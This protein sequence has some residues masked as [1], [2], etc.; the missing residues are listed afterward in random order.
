MTQPQSK[1]AQEQR[2]HDLEV[3][4]RSREREI[5]LLKDTVTA[6]GGELDLTKVFEL[7][8]ERA[9]ELIQ[10]ETLLIPVLDDNAEHYT[11]RAG[12]GNNAAEIIGQS[13][14]LDFGVCGWVWRHKRAW[15]RGVLDELEPIERNRWENEAGTLIL[16]PMIGRGQFLGGLAG[17]NKLGGG[18]FTRQDLNLLSLFAGH[19]SIAIENAIAYAALNEAKLH[20]ETYQIE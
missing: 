11:Y 16:V 5:E 1:N 7:V 12:A 6:V 13:L 9:R 15:W 10:A 2:L 19:V 8:A 4:L 14:P 20:A 17:I 18:D 3:A